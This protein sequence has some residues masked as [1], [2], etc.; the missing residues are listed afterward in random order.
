MFSVFG[1]Y[2]TVKVIAYNIH[3]KQEKIITQKNSNTVITKLI[4]DAKQ[5][6]S[7]KWERENKEFWYNNKMYDLIRTEKHKNYTIYYCLKDEKE[8]NLF[9]EFFQIIK[10]QSDD[11]SSPLANAAKL[12]FKIFSGAILDQ[13]LY[14]FSVQVSETPF[15]NFLQLNYSCMFQRVEIPPP[16]FISK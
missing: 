2:T 1:I 5:E 11:K 13:L 16:E 10:Q 4:I 14:G 7:F 6:S 12:L 8:T 9:H 15:Y 3:Q